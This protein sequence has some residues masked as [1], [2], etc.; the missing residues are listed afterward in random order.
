MADLR[1]KKL[2]VLKGVLFAAL[3]AGASALIL[4]E[5]PNWRVLTALL[6][7]IWASARF[8]YFPFYVL[9]NYVDSSLKY[10]GLWALLTELRRRPRR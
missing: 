5:A 6:I 3:I 7:V 4:A 9:E 10:A 2:I 1:S 8:Y